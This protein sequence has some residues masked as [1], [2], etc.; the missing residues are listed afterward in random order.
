MQNAVKIVKKNSKKYLSLD[1]RS[2]P[3]INNALLLR[4]IKDYYLALIRIRAKLWKLFGS[5]NGR[6]G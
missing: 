5:K 3:G 1:F 4:I 6:K 2:E